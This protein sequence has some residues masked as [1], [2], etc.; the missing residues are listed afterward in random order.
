MNPA[1]ITEDINNKIAC[2]LTKEKYPF[3]KDLIDTDVGIRVS[4]SII[5]GAIATGIIGI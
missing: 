3:I 4:I 5:G 1:R 2:I